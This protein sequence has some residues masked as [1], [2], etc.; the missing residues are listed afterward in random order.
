[1]SK[2]LNHGVHASVGKVSVVIPV[3]NVA[4]HLEACV[5]SVIQQTLQDIEIICVDDASTDGSARILRMLQ[6]ED[7]RVKVLTLPENLTANQA[8]KSGVLASSG[9][10]VMFLDGDDELLP[11]ACETAL[12]AMNEHKVD[13]VHFGARVINKSGVPKARIQWNQNKIA[14]CLDRIEGDLIAACFEKNRFFFT[15][16]NKAFR[17]N[18]AREAFAHIQDG[19]FPRAQDLYAVFILMHFVRSYQGIA[20]VLLNYHFGNGITGQRVYEIPSFE[21]FCQAS[22]VANAIRDFAYSKNIFERY[23]ETI[24]KIRKGLLFDAL[25]Q[26]MNHLRPQDS[27]A[28]Y[29]LLAQNWGAE[30][31]VAALAEKSVK[32]PEKFGVKK[33]A[34]LV[35]GSICISPQPFT[36]LHSVKKRTIGVFY[37]RFHSGGVQRVISLLI[38]IFMRMGCRVVLITE[39]HEPDSEYSLP[40]GVARVQIPPS[41][42]GENYQERADSLA[43]VLREYEI[44]VLS[45]HATSGLGC[46][47][48]LLLAKHLGCRV[49]LSRHETAF[50]SFLNGTDLPVWQPAVYALADEL[51]VLTRMDEQYYRLMGVRTVFVPNPRPHLDLQPLSVRF[52]E[53]IVLWVGRMDFVQKQCMEPIE[54]MQEVIHSVPGAKLLMVG[55][56]WSQDAE[57]TLRDRIKAL[58]LQNNVELLGYTPQPEKYYHQAACQLVTSSWENYPMVIEES[59]AFGLPLVMY[60]LPYLELLQSGKGY[61]SVEQMD[62]QAAAHAIVRLLQNPQLREDLGRQAQ[63]ELAAANDD[64]LEQRWKEIL[65]FTP[66]AAS[67]DEKMDS[68]RLRMLL[69]NMLY[70]YGRGVARKKQETQRL[71]GRIRELAAAKAGPE[72]GKLPALSSSKRTET[73][74]GKGFPSLTELQK[75]REELGPIGALDFLIEREKRMAKGS[76]L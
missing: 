46:V 6:T 32:E 26:W 16:W 15:L 57:Q 30:E 24:L 48:D 49:V 10:M 18:L 38:P 68:G 60:E 1:M 25:G 70:L 40:Q 76:A 71:N 12:R 36:E 58:G 66:R 23:R 31:L 20:D 47:F 19:R 65:S 34:H 56:G 33:I 64:L 50:A 41:A 7:A 43:A 28:G 2:R 11:H 22:R 74:R 21:R 67:T 63:A 39:E 61:I 37:Y 13:V 14:P 62:R 51:T 75:R 29:D 55:G 17:G 54:I 27:A 4:A 69:E 8:R 42:K 3:F 73:G 44:D 35:S 53:P 9:D 5:R 59:R 72:K 45:Y 52:A